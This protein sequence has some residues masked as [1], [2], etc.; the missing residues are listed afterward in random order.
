MWNFLHSELSV[1]CSFD[2]YS[3]LSVL[4]LIVECWVLSLS[5]LIWVLSHYCSGFSVYLLSFQRPIF[6][7]LYLLS[8]RCLVLTFCL[9]SV[10]APCL[11]L[12]VGAQCLVL[13]VG[14]APVG[15]SGQRAFESDSQ[16]RDKSR[17]TLTL[18]ATCLFTRLESLSSLD[19]WR[20]RPTLN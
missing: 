6:S 16:G 14:A 3:V 2:K 8:V 9:L 4:C 20:G 1:Q 19:T 11:V 7:V 17:A 5:V 15:I 18:T 12:S 13:S 10:G